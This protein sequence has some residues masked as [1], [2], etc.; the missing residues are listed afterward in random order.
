[1]YQTPPLNLATFAEALFAKGHKVKIIDMNKR[2][3][4][5]LVRLMK[6][7]SPDFVGISFVTPLAEEAFRLARLVKDI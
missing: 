4:D 7:Y 1:M 6:S 2:K 5:D 3:D